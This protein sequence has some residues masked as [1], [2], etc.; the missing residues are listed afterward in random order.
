MSSTE[1]TPVAAPL[2]RVQVSLQDAVTLLSLLDVAD[3][4]AA[5]A[6]L[7]AAAA[8]PAPESLVVSSKPSSG[9]L[10][11]SA[12][13]RAAEGAAPTPPAPAVG[14]PPT[15]VPSELVLP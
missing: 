8:A 1:Q 14:H 11:L 3:A 6:E 12:P 10:G 13:L 5:A 2:G 7:D 9:A 15:A 4:E